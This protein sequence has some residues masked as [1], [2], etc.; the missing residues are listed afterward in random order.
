MMLKKIFLAAAA[1]ALS[2]VFASCSSF[3][4]AANLNDMKLSTNPNVTT[5]AHVNGEVWGVYL[6]GVIPFFSGSTATPDR[7]VMFEDTVTIPRTVGMVVKTSQAR[8]NAQYL[9]NMTTEKTS[10]WLFPTLLFWYKS[11]QISA[12]AM[13]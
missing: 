2:V 10:T 11:I 7:C 9:D 12:N 8:L 1:A 13:R 3:N 4:T 5:I 6:L